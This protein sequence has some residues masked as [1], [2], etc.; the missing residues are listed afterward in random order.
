MNFDASAE[1]IA[2]MAA[3]GLRLDP[4]PTETEIDEFCAL[5]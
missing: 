5:G 2:R 3:Q 1:N 4:P